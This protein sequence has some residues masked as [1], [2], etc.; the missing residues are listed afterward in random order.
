[1]SVPNGLTKRS[2]KLTNKPLTPVLASGNV[3]DEYNFNV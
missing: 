1:M 2:N 3:T